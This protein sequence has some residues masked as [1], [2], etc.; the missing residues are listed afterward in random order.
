M[1]YCASYVCLWYCLSLSVCL[2]VSFV[3]RPWNYIESTNDYY[4]CFANLDKHYLYAQ[5]NDLTTRR[6][7][8]VSLSIRKKLKLKYPSIY[9][10]LAIDLSVHPTLPVTG[11]VPACLSA[12]P[13]DHFVSIIII[14]ANLCRYFTCAVHRNVIHFAATCVTWTTAP[15]GGGLSYWSLLLPRVHNMYNLLCS[16]NFSTYKV[17]LLVV[18]LSYSIVKQERDHHC[19]TVTMPHVKLAQVNYTG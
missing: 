16:L 3:C 14:N 8:N 19:R 9:I 4:V 2:I 6:Q 1:H 10:H 13:F 18:P 5:R 11:W 17:L 12:S 15:C 7:R